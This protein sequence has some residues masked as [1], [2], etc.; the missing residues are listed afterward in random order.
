MAADLPASSSSSA[1][2]ELRAQEQRRLAAAQAVER[3]QAS[4]AHLLKMRRFDAAR[5]QLKD[6]AAQRGDE[7]ELAQA[8]VALLELAT[9]LERGAIDAPEKHAELARLVERLEESNPV[10]RPLESAFLSGRWLL[11]YTTSR[12]I[13]GLDGR[14]KPVRRSGNHSAVPRPA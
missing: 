4:T 1:L 13:L 3:F 12:S 14:S 9:E 8:R 2:T 11:A 6:E 10:A 7:L 5:R